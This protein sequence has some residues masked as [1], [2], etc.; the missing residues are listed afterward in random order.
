MFVVFYPITCA[1]CYKNYFHGK[2]GGF[3]NGEIIHLIEYV[4]CE[5][6]PLILVFASWGAHMQEETFVLGC[7]FSVISR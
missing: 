6:L 2:K 1:W 7:T 4:M 3:S 5:S